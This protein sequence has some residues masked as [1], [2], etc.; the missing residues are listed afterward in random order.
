MGW[1]GVLML[2]VTFIWA[3]NA[4]AGKFALRGFSP[5]ALAELRVVGATAGFVLVYI[6]LRGWPKLHFTRREWGFMALAG[7]NGVTLNQGFYLS[8]LSRTSVAHTALIVALGPV[9]VLV[10]ACLLRM[11][12]L[13]A[14]KSLGMV[15]AFCGVAALTIGKPSEASGA[16]WLGDILMLAG[17]VAF[18][19]YTILLK[20]GAGRYDTLTLSMVT[21]GLGA[22]MLAPFSVHAIVKTRWQAAPPLAWVGLAFMIIFASVVA[23]LLFAHV[24]T[25]MTASQAAAYI[26][27]SPVIAIGLGVWLLSEIITWKVL[28]GGGMILFGL[29]LTGKGKQE[30][31]AGTAE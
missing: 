20:Q 30:P 31:E 13:T 14:A 28:V 26:Y 25:V 2:C 8:G 24:L 16:S 17:R 9:V 23:Y 22:L 10:L 5:M 1:M 21:F 27:L 3:A 18:A 12:A 19:Y 29:F 11:E 4:V 15:I 7:L 6:I